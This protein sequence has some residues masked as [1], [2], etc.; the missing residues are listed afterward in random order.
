[1]PE[2]VEMALKR[3]MMDDRHSA[4]TKFKTMNGYEKRKVSDNSHSR[5]STAQVLLDRKP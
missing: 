1:M 4:L 5:T 2:E 3:K